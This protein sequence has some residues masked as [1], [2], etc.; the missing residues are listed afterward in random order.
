MWLTPVL[1]D[2][3]LSDKGD[4]I[5]PADRLLQNPTRLYR[6]VAVRNVD[7]PIGD[8]K[9]TPLQIIEDHVHGVVADVVSGVI[10][11]PCLPAEFQR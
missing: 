3:C 5:D 9:P 6:I 7:E 1:K 8:G 2:T 10:R 4:R 11:K